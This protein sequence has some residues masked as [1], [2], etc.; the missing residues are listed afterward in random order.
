VDA[1]ERS[2][3]PLHAALLLA[4]IAALTTGSVVLV[5]QHT[6]GRIAANEVQARQ[7]RIAQI[8]ETLAYDNVPGNDRITVTDE[9]LGRTQQPVYRARYTGEP[10]ASVIQVTTSD[11]YSGSIVLLVGVD[12]QG[13]VLAVRTLDHRETPG[14]GDA[15]D[16]AKHDWITGFDGASLASPPGAWAV[17]RD[18]GQFDQMTGATVTSRAVVGAVHDALLYFDR[19]GQRFFSQ[20]PM[21]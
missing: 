19:H 12:L 15:I 11:G 10:V 8:L 6:A 16:I 13:K 4:A 20:S 9:L 18:G 21:Q 14:L 17:R 5:K 7:Q 1:P 3:N 2:R